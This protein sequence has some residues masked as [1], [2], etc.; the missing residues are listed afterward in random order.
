MFPFP[1]QTGVKAKNSEASFLFSPKTQSQIQY[2]TPRRATAAALCSAQRCSWDPSSA[3]PH[4]NVG[5]VVC[6]RTAMQEQWAPRAGI[7]SAS[8]PHPA[9]LSSRL[10]AKHPTTWSTILQ[11]Q[12][13]SSLSLFFKPDASH[14]YWRSLGCACT[15]GLVE[16]AAGQGNGFRQTGCPWDVAHFSLGNKQLHEEPKKTG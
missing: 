16:P 15:E 4:P 7:H 1:T 9:S 10:L 6:N 2:L 11:V 5:T 13:V 8:T 3:E 14:L 12:P